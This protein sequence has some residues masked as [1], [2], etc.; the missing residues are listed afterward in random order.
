[1]LQA[2]KAFFLNDSGATAL[3]Y[4]LIA[5]LIGVFCIT[6]IQTVGTKASNTFNVIANTLQ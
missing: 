1:M 4:A 6:I 5:S 2:T 3:E